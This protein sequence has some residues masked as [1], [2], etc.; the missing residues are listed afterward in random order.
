MSTFLIGI[1]S[2][3][4]INTLSDDPS[5]CSWTDPTWGVSFNYYALS[6]Q[7][8]GQL[9]YYTVKDSHKDS[10]E[11]STYTYYFNLCDSVLEYPNPST[12]NPNLCE[13]ND[14]H[15]FTF[16]PSSSIHNDGCGVNET[17]R[18]AIANKG[19]AYQINEAQDAC[20]PLSSGS[21]DDVSISLYDH[22]DPTQGII[23]KHTNG[24]WADSCGANREF[25]IKL[26]C[27]DDP[28][29]V[30]RQTDV[31]E[32]AK[33][34]YQMTIYTMHGCP[35]GCGAYANSLCAAQGLCGYDFST[36]RSRC[37]CYHE[38]GG[39]ACEQV[40]SYSDFLIFEI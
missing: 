37:F 5:E 39:S 31:T 6:L 1:F 17:D 33:C 4:T 20:Y 24:E 9:D 22:L 26:K 19:F 35:S 21:A 12:A 15:K 38:F 34:K 18:T 10:E 2:L 36:N 11:T 23:I 30:P 14:D 40:E 27:E 25:T 28:S 13:Y 7:S 29:S 3:L 32:Y 8:G 16:C